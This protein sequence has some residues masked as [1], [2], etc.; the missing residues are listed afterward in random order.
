MDIPTYEQYKKPHGL[1]PLS[2]DQISDIAHTLQDLD[3]N[4]ITFQ[5]NCTSYNSHQIKY[6]HSLL[7]SK[8]Y[9]VDI[10]ISGTVAYGLKVYLQ[11][12]EST[13]ATPYFY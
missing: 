2:D 11:D 9:R 3:P 1:K 8:G 7:K 6:L 13:K 12:D 4:T 5:F 10:F